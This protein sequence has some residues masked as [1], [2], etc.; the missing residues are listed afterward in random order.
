[1]S[2]PSNIYLYKGANFGASI[3][4]VD[5]KKGIVSG[6]FAAFNNVDSDGDVIR[7]GAFSKSIQEWGPNSSSPRIKH[8]MNHDIAKP[9]GKITSLHEDVKGLA[10]ES[11]VG[12][13]ALG[14][15][16]VKMVESNLITEHSIGF[17]VMKRNQLQDYEGYMKNPDA[18]WYELTDI[19]LY[20]GSSLTAWGSNPNTPLTGMKGEKIEDVAQRII[21]R[22][23]NIEKFCRNSTATDET[24]ELLL[25]ENQQLSQS[26]IEFVK[27][28]KNDTSHNEV[29]KSI[30][31]AFKN[32][33]SQL[34]IS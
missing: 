17:R 18:G 20:E 22:Q 30:R 33:N 24:I 31:E 4:D 29:G 11:Q 25:I 10:Y 5:G 9:L 16:F 1:M 21:N 6:Y 32:F 8:L 28:S 15:D 2:T 12:T 26:L 13:H 7:K 19:K 23:Q 14:Q 34:Q 3:K 27:Q